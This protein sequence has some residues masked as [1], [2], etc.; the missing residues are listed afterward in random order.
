M[1]KHWLKMHVDS[2]VLETSL[3][4]KNNYIAQNQ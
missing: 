2:A 4:T 1:V 3:L